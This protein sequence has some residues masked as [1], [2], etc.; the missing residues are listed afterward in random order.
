MSSKLLSRR[1]FSAQVAASIPFVAAGLALRSNPLRAGSADRGGLS[2]A[3]GAIH[4]EVVFKASRKRV[5][6]ALTEA[7]R[8]TDVTKFSM[9]G[10]A[11]PAEISREA[12]GAFA[13]FGGYVTGRHVEL[14][15]DQRIVQAW[16]AGSWEEGVY[17]IVRFDL[18]EEREGT[19]LVFDHTGFPTDQGEHLAAG[20][21]QNYWEP[22][23]KYL[24]T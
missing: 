15:P 9:V 7:A 17:S 11:P 12:G 10:N 6:E 20:W 22:L 4:Q 2:H 23:A 3:A 14:K 18:Q 21:K 5:Y 13:C 8:F 16:R 19:K 24:E 1:K